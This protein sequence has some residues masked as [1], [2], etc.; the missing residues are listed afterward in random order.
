MGFEI[1]IEIE[2]GGTS[3]KLNQFDEDGKVGGQISGSAAP[4]TSFNQATLDSYFGDARRAAWWL[5]HKDIG[6]VTVG[7]YEGA[8]AQA[9]IDL[10]GIGQFASNSF[11]LVMAGNYLRG[12]AGQFYAMKWTDIVDPAVASSQRTEVVR[13][14][15]PSL[16]GFIGSA[17]IAEAGDY[18]GVMLR[19]ANEFNGVRVA[20]GIGYEQIRDR[21]TP[22][23]LDPTAAFFVGARPDEV[24]WGVALSAMHV[25]T[26]LFIQ[27]HYEHIDFGDPHIVSA[28]WN[29]AGGATKK[30]AAQ[31]LIQAGVARNWMGWG[32]TIL[33]A[34]YGR[35]TDWG[36]DS[37]GRTFAGATTLSC[38]AAGA[39][40]GADNA[41]CSRTIDNF[42]TITGVTSTDV[43]VWGLG[44][45]Q[46]LDAAA[47][48]LY[49]TYRNFDADIT[50]GTTSVPTEQMHVVTGGAI[51][52]F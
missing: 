44:L 30:D 3:S 18:W 10:G 31:W 47:S 50:T 32:N 28:Y 43:R 25:P 5:E 6:R 38:G 45:G 16:M 11:S 19:Y 49:L 37:A 22:A 51:V 21:S 2:A 33:Y 46:N 48:T 40:G 23:T 1:M 13:Y 12:P 34:E 36:A 39:A 42:T 17:S 4:G 52:R 8:G 24:A 26:G 27:G 14:D 15:S 20:A 9:T 41:V 29:D 7:R 35:A